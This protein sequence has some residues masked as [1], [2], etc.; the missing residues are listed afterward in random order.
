MNCQ[1]ARF[2]FL[3]SDEAKARLV[4]ALAPGNL[5]KTKNAPITVIVALDTRFFEHL[6]TQF[7][8]YGAKPVFEANADLA[9][10]RT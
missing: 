8:A 6:P 1:P 10:S 3:R 5:E 9:A 2:V 4:P 7:K